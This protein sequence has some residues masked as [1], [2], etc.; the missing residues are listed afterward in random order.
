MPF[1]R[2]CA[3][4]THADVSKIF[5]Q[6]SSKCRSGSPQYHALPVPSLQVQSSQIPTSTYPGM[7][8]VFCNQ[9]IRSLGKQDKVAYFIKYL[10]KEA[11]FSPTLGLPCHP[12]WG[13]WIAAET[14]PN[15]RQCMCSEPLHPG[16]QSGFLL[17]SVHEETGSYKSKNEEFGV[18]RKPSF[19]TYG[20]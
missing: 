14:P 3:P 19:L 5:L 18:S 1:S 9:L 20:L 15:S 7:V 6:G 4:E 12:Y 16:D 17:Q 11:M 8:H 10:L 13:G 2:M